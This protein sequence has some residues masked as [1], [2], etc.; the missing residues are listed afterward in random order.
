MEVWIWKWWG[1]KKLEDESL[2]RDYTDVECGV[3][4]CYYKL[5]IDLVYVQVM[6]LDFGRSGLAM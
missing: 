4:I 1:K 5:T 2:E 6:G 3:F